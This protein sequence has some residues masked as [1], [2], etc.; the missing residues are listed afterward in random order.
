MDNIT[1]VRTIV[2]WLVGGH[3]IRSLERLSLEHNNPRANPPGNV[4]EYVTAQIAAS[5]SS[6]KS[7]DI[8]E[9]YLEPAIPFYTNINLEHI[10]LKNMPIGLLNNTLS[11]VSSKHV[12]TISITPLNKVG[13]LEGFDTLGSI[14]SLSKFS[15]LTKIHVRMEIWEDW[16]AQGTCAKRREQRKKLQ[17]EVR[18]R[19]SKLCE[20]SEERA[21]LEMKVEVCESQWRCVL[22]RGDMIYSDD[23]VSED[24]EDQDGQGLSASL[25]ESGYGG[26]EHGRDSKV[27]YEKIPAAEKKKWK[28]QARRMR[29]FEPQ[30]TKV[31][32]VP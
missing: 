1:F 19:L 21:G 26:R 15:S 5:G 20:M 8:S 12:S 10:S 32:S 25:W 29:M 4:Y 30:M 16:M 18:R 7:V 22:E 17:E 27:V 31:E 28:H 24:D 11:T 23:E 9:D 6:L 3:L 2:P 14:L 13:T